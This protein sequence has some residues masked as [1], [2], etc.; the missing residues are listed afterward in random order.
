M[1]L[2]L[3]RRAVLGA[4]PMA[5]LG[6]TPA[7]ADGLIERRESQYNTIYITREGPYVAMQFGVNNQLFTE[8]LY[9]PSRPRFLPMEYTRMMT[10]SLA[11]AANPA[12]V[13]EIGLGGGR[14]AVYLT[15]HVPTLSVTAVELDPEVVAMANKHFGVRPSARLR[16]ET[17]DG[18]IFLTQSRDRYDIIIVDAYRGTFVP[19]HL[20]TQ[21]FFI[22]AKRKLNPG[23]AVVQN[24][25]PNVVLTESMIA[26]LQAVFDNV[27]TYEI[28]G[29]VIAISYDGPPKTQAALLARATALQNQYRFTHALPMLARSRVTPPKSAR[30]PLTDDF[31]PVEHLRGIQAHNARRK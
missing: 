13:L 3:T 21:Q 14:T 17:S 22:L 5:A 7:F 20:T 28:A 31:A 2:D 25:A 29:S 10:L 27:D 12:K 23:G 1:T 6:A 19:F 30:R 26:T 16:V 9:D 24:I 15:D 8:N 11:Y 18:R 4:L